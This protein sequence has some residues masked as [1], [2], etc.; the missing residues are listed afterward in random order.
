MNLTTV[1]SPDGKGLRQRESESKVSKWTTP[2]VWKIYDDNHNS[3]D[4]DHSVSRE[5]GSAGSEGAV[6]HLLRQAERLH[7]ARYRRL[8]IY[9][10]FV[11]SNIRSGGRASKKWNR[12][13]SCL[14]IPREK[15]GSARVVKKNYS[16]HVDP[17]NMFYT[18][19]G[20]PLSY[21]QP[22]EQL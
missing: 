4:A 19:S 6:D 8:I 7:H 18:W 11:K 15:G 21:L 14:A 10:F 3:A 22:L 12:M 16:K 17:Q 20:V 13:V 2:V 5:A 9:F 1:S